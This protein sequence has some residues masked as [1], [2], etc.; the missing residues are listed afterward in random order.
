M[1]LI[2]K[3]QELPKHNIYI[4]GKKAT[5]EEVAALPPNPKGHI[6]EDGSVWITTEDGSEKKA[7][8]LESNNQGSKNKDK[9]DYTAV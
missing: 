8:T 7:L 5:G 1:A 3:S 4:D 2:Q 6:A 9:R